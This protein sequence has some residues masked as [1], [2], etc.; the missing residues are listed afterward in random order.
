MHK[1]RALGIRL[2]GLFRAR[3]SDGDFA[4]ELVSHVELHTEA[5]IRAGLPPKKRVA[6]P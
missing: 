2:R 6:R 3:R 4:A 1:L 5:N